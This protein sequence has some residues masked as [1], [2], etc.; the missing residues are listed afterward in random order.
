[1]PATELSEDSVR[2]L[3][4]ASTARGTHSVRRRAW[5]WGGASLLACS[6]ALLGI[7][8]SRGGSGHEKLKIAISN[9]TGYSPFYVALKDGQ[10]P[11]WEL[12][13]RTQL[14]RADRNEIITNKSIHAFVGTID[15]CVTDID[16]LMLHQIRPTCILI[17]AR[18]EG[19]DAIV[20]RRNMKTIRDLKGKEVR[21]WAGSS[22]YY[23]L[24]YKLQENGMT[25][26]DVKFQHIE[27]PTDLVEAFKS[28][29]VDAIA[30]WSPWLEIASQE[31]V[32]IAT[33][34][35]NHGPP[36]IYDVLL[37]HDTSLLSSRREAFLELFGGW[38]YGIQSIRKQA[39]KVPNG[40]ADWMNL[41][42]DQCELA[43]QKVRYYS[44]REN[45]EELSSWSN[46][47]EKVERE[48]TLAGLTRSGTPPNIAL[49]QH[50]AREYLGA[51]RQ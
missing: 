42:D 1:L 20:A 7:L 39:P 28:G 36:D 43:H 8:L 24:N 44:V 46:L 38:N 47:V 16:K 21:A 29:K 40:V 4:T 51:K 25:L 37:V 15:A 22:S 17:L 50:F 35:G 18:S 13:D 27:R 10:L 23:L 19:G 9:W 45:V 32:V 31:G 30:T 11:N 3:P 12:V 26:E 14:S 5:I 48:S 2:P 49:F 41:A 6:L 34:G 33:C